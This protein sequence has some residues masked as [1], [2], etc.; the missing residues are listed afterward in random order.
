M[1]IKKVSVIGLGALGILVGSQMLKKMP[2]GDLRVIADEGRIAR[3][4][5]DGVY[6]NGELCDFHYVTPDEPGGPADLLIFA[7]KFSGLADAV[8]AA[9]N[10]VGPNTVILSVLNGISSETVIGAAYGDDKVICCVA[11]GMDAVKVGNRLTYH[12]PGYLCF[13]EQKPGIVTERI[14]A[15]A[16]FFDKMGIPYL[17][18]T[19][20]QK[21]MWGKFMLNVGV[22]QIA[23]VY[24]CNYGGLQQEGVFRDM[25]ILAMREVLALS[26]KERAGLTEADLDYWLTVINPLHPDGK[27][28]MQQDAEAKRLSEVELFAGTVLSLGEKHGISTP[29]NR[30][31]YDKIQAMESKY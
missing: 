23:A 8:S 3:Y 19:D 12:T 16:R 26:D 20:M 25:M 15:V 1:E 13:G 7:V 30:L 14:E 22:N 2:A 10:H 29:V 5:S 17:K 9:K 28:S 18:K 6:C 27:P 11:Q 31:L 24:G 21:H 4:K